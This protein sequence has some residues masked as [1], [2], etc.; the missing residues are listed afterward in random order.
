M[1]MSF[2]RTYVAR[3]FT[4]VELLAVLAI[5]ALLAVL[6]STQ[7]S[8]MTA[9]SQKAACIANMRGIG[10]ALGVYSAEYNG[11]VCPA[12]GPHGGTAEKKFWYEILAD[13]DPK[14]FTKPQY[15]KGPSNPLC[16]A[17]KGS[18]KAP[19]D[20]SQSSIYGGYGYNRGL[21]IDGDGLAGSQQWIAEEAPLSRISAWVRPSRTVALIDAGFVWIAEWWYRNKDEQFGFQWRHPGAG[22]KAVNILML[23]GHV[24]TVTMSTR[25]TYDENNKYPGN[26]IWLQNYQDPPN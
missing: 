17:M 25:P 13:Y 3:A 4:L 22:N 5:I 23:D 2:Q 19:N 20:L 12:F 11:A 15:D 26:L 24:E 8:R 1:R 18:S 9:S 10:G 16:P 6:V 7:I 21:G 14:F